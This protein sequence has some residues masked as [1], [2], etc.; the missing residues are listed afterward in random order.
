MDIVFCLGPGRSGTTLLRSILDGKEELVVWPFEFAYY[1][2]INTKLN[3]NKNDSKFK[4]KTFYECV[5]SDLELLSKETYSYDLGSEIDEKRIYKIDPSNYKKFI[6]YFKN[7]NELVTTKQFLIY[8]FEKYKMFYSDNKKIKKYFVLFHNLPSKKLLR[9]FPKSK[10]ILSVRNPVD[11]YISRREFYFTTCKNI[12]KDFSLAYK[13]F[14]MNS[15][16]LTLFDSTI[17]PIIE[18]DLFLKNKIEHKIFI[19]LEKLTNNS[20]ITLSHL[21]DFM[22]IKMSTSLNTNTFLGQRHYSN[23]NKQI[24]TNA[25]ILKYQG[26]NMK[27]NISELEYYLLSR[28][29]RK[30]VFF[31]IYKS[32]LIYPYKINF[33]K[34]LSFFPNEFPKLYNEKIEMK[35]GSNII[36]ILFYILKLI[37]RC[38]YFPINYIINRYYVFVKNFN[39]LDN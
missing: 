13:P 17:K 39:V 30:K 8:L 18:F 9:D 10:Y 4:I 16:A 32:S 28:N 35:F 6:K 15:R 2:T 31:G 23:M 36:N 34:K 20:H 19:E 21:M 25:K 38:V 22:N 5:K 3:I 24:N 7:N 12:G 11:L 26:Y 27:K 14:S 37:N 33:F 1:N 29:F